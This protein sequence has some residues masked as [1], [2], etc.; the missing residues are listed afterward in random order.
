L[1]VYKNINDVPVDY[2]RDKAKTIRK[3]IARMFMISINGHYGGSFSCTEIV[4]ALYFA[5]MRIDPTNPKW[6]E[7]DRFVLSKG[8]CAATVYGALVEL[9]YFP[10]EWIEEYEKLGCHLNTHPNM[11]K[12]P[13]IDMSSGSLGHGLSCAVGMALAAKMK[14]K[15]YRTFVLLGDGESHEGSIWEAAMSAY[16]YKLDNLIA[17]TDKNRLCVDG[18]LD[19]VMPLDPLDKK[20]ESFGWDVYEI[21]GHSFEEILTTID[22]AISDKNGK[23]KMIIAN[24][25][26]GKGV[27][28][29]ENNREWHAHHITEELNEKIMAE[30][31]A[32]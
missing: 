29:M 31:E 17:F 24:T 19:E 15:D 18:T 20:W 10:K 3:H 12:V 27:S 14:K 4:T 7:R 28:F 23:P 25:I 13:G 2:L 32:Q 11:L 21:D 22:N 1:K 5:V 6:D 16:K 30:L 9:G 26:K 8:H